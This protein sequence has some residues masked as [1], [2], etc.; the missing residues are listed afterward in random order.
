MENPEL[1]DR[2]IIILGETHLDEI[3][4]G[5]TTKKIAQ[6]VI[7]NKDI[8]PDI[9]IFSESVKP[10]TF[11]TPLGIK[12]TIPIKNALGSNVQAL[13]QCVEFIP[14]L[15]RNEILKSFNKTPSKAIEIIMNRFANITISEEDIVRNP[16]KTLHIIKEAIKSMCMELRGQNAAIILENL[17][18]IVPGPVPGTICYQAALG[19]VNDEIV[20]NIHEQH[21]RQAPDVAFIIVTGDSHRQDITQQLLSSHK[22][23]IVKSI[24]H[25]EKVSPLYINSLPIDGGKRRSIYKNRKSRKRN[26]KHRSRKFK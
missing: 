7:E 20:E 26:K 5:V 18:S 22:R 3:E 24:V 15:K 1:K 21:L 6:I 19:L 14:L 8:F 4:R 25:D 23:Y 17:D 12:T 11:N 10:Q 9:V 16:M 13:F 2:I